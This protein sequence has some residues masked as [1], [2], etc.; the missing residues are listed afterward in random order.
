MCVCVG[1]PGADGHVGCYVD[2]GDGTRDL[3]AKSE[4]AQAQMTIDA[5]RKFC[6]GFKYFG[7]QFSQECYCGN[8]IGKFGVAAGS[9]CNMKCSGS[10][11]VCGGPSRNSVYCEWGFS[12]ASKL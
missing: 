4:V 11:E 2:L 1:V 8:T 6:S 5:C 3:S 7:T 12:K 10:A 9:D